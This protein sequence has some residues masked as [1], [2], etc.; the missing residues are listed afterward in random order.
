MNIRSTGNEF[1]NLV[2]YIQQ[3]RSQYSFQSAGKSECTS[4]G[5]EVGS[6][7]KLQCSFQWLENVNVRSTGNEFGNLVIYIL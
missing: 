3:L 4:T 5:D 1:G 6:F 2:I 7:G